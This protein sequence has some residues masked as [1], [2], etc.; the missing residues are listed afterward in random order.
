MLKPFVPHLNST[1]ER[2]GI[3]NVRVCRKEMVVF[4]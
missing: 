3:A 2:R 4:G 1:G